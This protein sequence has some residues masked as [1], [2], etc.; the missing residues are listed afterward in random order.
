LD[1]E[2][3]NAGRVVHRAAD[4]R[5]HDERPG[6]CAGGNDALD[7]GQLPGAADILRGGFDV[8]KA[9]ARG[10]FL[11][12]KHDQF[13]ALR[14]ALQPQRGRRRVAGV[15]QARGHQRHRG[16]G[17]EHD[18]AAELFHHHH[19]IDR[20]EAHAAVRLGH[21][22]AEQAQ[23]GQVFPGVLRVAAGLD[24]AAPPLERVA[25]VDP[26]AHRVAQH[27]LVV[28]EI[29][30]HVITRPSQSSDSIF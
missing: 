7:A 3:R 30:V 14:D 25:L 27:F 28:A 5:R 15:Q 10:A 12:R 19:R 9:V 24:D 17:F 21:V 13:A 6:V 2:Q 11:V 23:I 26:F 20:P 8:G 1:H 29:E 18:A 22:Q 4:A 16:V